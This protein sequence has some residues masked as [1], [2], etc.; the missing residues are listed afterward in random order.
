MDHRGLSPG[1]HDVCRG[2][3]KENETPRSVLKDIQM[4]SFSLLLQTEPVNKAL[5]SQ[6]TDPPRRSHAMFLMSLHQYHL[7]SWKVKKKSFHVDPEANIS[8][9]RDLLQTDKQTECDEIHSNTGGW[10]DIFTHVSHFTALLLYTAQRH[11]YC[12]L[13]A[14]PY[15][16]YQRWKVNP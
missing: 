2:Y 12:K 3:C 14:V 15:I 13:Q 7:V 4:T 6:Y 1:E 8:P 11:S 16:H 9:H 5:S 10:A